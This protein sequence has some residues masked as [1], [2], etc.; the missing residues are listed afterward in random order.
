V[1]VVASHYLPTPALGAV[2]ALNQRTDQ[3][4]GRSATV[5][6][7]FHHGHGA[8]TVG[9]TRWSAEAIDGSDYTAGTKVEI[10]AAES[11]LL[12]VKRAA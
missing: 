9:D 2:S 10:V 8:V 6:E 4:V 11:T 5:A 1:L 12:K 3:M 7:D